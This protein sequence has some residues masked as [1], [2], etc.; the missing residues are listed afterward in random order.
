MIGKKGGY[1]IHNSL[2]QYHIENHKLK[3]NDVGILYVKN[4]F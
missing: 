4:W 1:S 3:E 2:G